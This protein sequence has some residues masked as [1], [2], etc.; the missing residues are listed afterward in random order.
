MHVM[1]MTMPNLGSLRPGDSA[2][3]I[4]LD[5]SEELYHRLAGLGV[6]V[7]KTVRLL[8]RGRFSGPLHIRIGTTDLML[9]VCEARAIRV[10]PLPS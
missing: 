4:A 8:R 7:G 6:R 1:P 3:V 10:R 9:R 2:T 5:V